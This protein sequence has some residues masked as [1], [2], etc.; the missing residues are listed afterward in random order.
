MSNQAAKHPLPQSMGDLRSLSNTT[1]GVVGHVH[2]AAFEVMVYTPHIIRI[3]ASLEQP[4]DDFSY[5]VEVAPGDCDFEVIDYPSEILLSTGQIKLVIQKSP[6][7]FAF[8][9]AFGKLLNQDDPAFGIMWSGT[10]VTSYRSLLEGERFIGL[11]EKTGPLDRRGFGYTNWNTDHFAYGAEGDPLYASVPF[12]IGCHASGCYGIYFDNTYKSHFNFGASNNRFSSFGAEGGDMDYYFIHYPTVAGIIE[13]YT[14]LTGRMSM[15]PKWALG[16]QQSRYSYYPEHEVMSVARTFRDKKIPAD[17]IYLDIHYMD[18]FKCFTW[19]KNR[20]P[21][22]AHMIQKLNAEGFHVA[23]ILDPGIKVE[24]RY[25]PYDDGLAQDVFVKYPDGTPYEGQVWPG[26]CHF[27]DFTDP[28]GREWWASKLKSLADEGVEGF[29]NDMNEF[30]TWG[31]RLPELM[32]F[33]FEGKTSST[34]RARN[35]YGMQM[36]RSTRQGAEKFLGN[37]RP[38]V[39]TR[40]AFAGSQRYTAI[41]TGDN[42]ASDE[43]LLLSVRLVNSLGLSGMPFAGP[44]IGGFVGRTWP[45]LYARW[46]SVGAFTPFFRGHSF[47]NTTDAEPWAFGEET[48]EI[49]RNYINLRYRLLPYLYSLFHEAS[50]TGM[51]IARSLAIDYT[52][53]PNIYDHSNHNQFLLGPY[54]LVCPVE[55][56]KEITKVYLPEG[57]WYDLHNDKCY[58]GGQVVYADCPIKRLPLFV[59]A[60]GILAMQDQVQHT[61]QPHSGQLTLHVYA[62]ESGISQWQLYE[63]D[64]T[65]N[66]YQS[67]KFCKRIFTYE[68]NKNQ[69]TIHSTQGD[70]KS[71]F[72]SIVLIMHGFAQ[73]QN[74]MA[75]GQK[76]PVEVTEHSFFKPISRFDAF[77]KEGTVESHQVYTVNMPLGQNEMIL[78]WKNQ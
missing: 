35:I 40:A 10:E 60:G 47:V 54:L 57:Q 69:I 29:W 8:F 46:A 39:L 26:W 17:I 78:E 3:R 73:V 58:A 41:W 76:Y 52:H 20:F 16:Y 61:M 11:G 38:F 7:R 25:E 63:D 21:D 53:D 65:T 22:P 27:P 77:G 51:P 5:S 34:K 68:G 9:D 75:N 30:A 50:V 49:V 19:D 64:G 71:D 59:K 36:S 2:S 13:G 55:S 14:W 32:H 4:F 37:K 12:Y 18:E 15:P 56:N 6:V 28:R 48:E 24:Q 1:R 42:V 33:N 23:V 45:E 66:D 67:G 74:L 43:H 72:E 62:A 31:N 70:F 44:D